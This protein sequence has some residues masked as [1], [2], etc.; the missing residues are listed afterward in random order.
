MRKENNL[1]NSFQ[2]GRELGLLS[3]EVAQLKEELGSIKSNIRCGCCSKLKDKITSMGSWN[4]YLVVL[5]STNQNI[6]DVSVIHTIGGI[7]DQ[8]QAAS[9]APNTSTKPI[10]LHGQSGSDDLWTIAFKLNGESIGRT[11]KQCNFEPEDANQT[12]YVALNSTDFSIVYPKSDSCMNN[13][14]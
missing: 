2:I 1:D 9:M 8:V 12:V 6:S 13:H 3:S 14:Y 10:K 11:G 5:N 4:G 7:T